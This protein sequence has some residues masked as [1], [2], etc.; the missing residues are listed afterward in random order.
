MP[1]DVALGWLRGEVVDAYW[2]CCGV[3]GRDALGSRRAAARR[4]EGGDEASWAAGFVAYRS[5]WLVAAYRCGG[6]ELCCCTAADDMTGL[7]V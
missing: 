1:G 7:C 2:G 6:G 3:F 4:E 5:C